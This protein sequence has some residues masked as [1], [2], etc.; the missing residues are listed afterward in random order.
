[1]EMKL[2]A[3]NLALSESKTELPKVIQ[4][5][6][7]TE[8]N[9]IIDKGQTTVELERARGVREIEGR[10]VDSLIALLKGRK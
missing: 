1:M 8:R 2:I 6:A 4:E 7:T 5:L 10:Y 3:S 9:M